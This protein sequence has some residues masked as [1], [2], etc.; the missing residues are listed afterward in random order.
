MT[1]PSVRF[2]GSLTQ[3]YAGGVCDVQPPRLNFLR[4]WAFSE[5]GHAGI[6]AERQMTSVIKPQAISGISPA[7]FFRQHHKGDDG[8]AGHAATPSAAGAAS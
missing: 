5:S 7:A 6:A 4:R 3:Y 8:D 2:I 1:F